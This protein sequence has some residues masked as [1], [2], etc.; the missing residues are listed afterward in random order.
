MPPT[1][2]VAARNAAFAGSKKGERGS[3]SLT[4]IA[5]GHRLGLFRLLEDETHLAVVVD[6]DRHCPAA[7]EAAEQE[8]VGQ[9][10]ADRVLDEPRH[11]PRTHLRIEA[12]LRQE[13]LALRPHSPP[14][15]RLALLVRV[16]V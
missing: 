15:R 16:L 14:H 6:V 8:L 2:P 3:K 10:L 7:D 12:I 5:S 4:P 13:S 9:R 11:R 1:K